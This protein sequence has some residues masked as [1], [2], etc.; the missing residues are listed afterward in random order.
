MRRRIQ[1]YSV[2]LI[3]PA[4]AMWVLLKIHYLTMGGGFSEFLDI[5][6][7]FGLFDATG[8]LMAGL[9]EGFFLLML[10]LLLLFGIS[11]LVNAVALY[12]VLRRWPRLQRSRIT[13]ILVFIGL[14]CFMAANLLLLKREFGFL[15][16]VYFVFA[17]WLAA[18]LILRIV[19]KY[20]LRIP[21]ASF[22]IL[23]VWL[24]FFVSSLLVYNQ[25][26]SL[27]GKY[28]FSPQ[29]YV[30]LRGIDYDLKAVGSTHTNIVYIPKFKRDVP[31]Y[32]TPDAP[33]RFIIPCIVIA[34]WLGL[35]NLANP[36]LVC[37]IGIPVLLAWVFIGHW[38]LFHF[39]VL[40]S[41]FILPFVGYKIITD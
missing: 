18:Y 5:L 30:P 39:V 6:K 11:Y 4:A 12:A 7:R 2:P 14:S 9:F 35:L 15:A 34:V 23:A 1:A 40:F 25:I 21:G 19:D 32:V 17:Q 38:E 3:L 31:E 26:S 22:P 24:L 29:K 28:D 27:S 13:A 16:F 36:G 37:G 10:I 41:I 33:G 20:G 8:G